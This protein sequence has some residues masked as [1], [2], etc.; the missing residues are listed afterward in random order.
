MQQHSACVQFTGVV[1]VIND[2][3]FFY[4]QRLHRSNKFQVIVRFYGMLLT[5]IACA[6]SLMSA[7][8]FHMVVIKHKLSDH[9]GCALYRAIQSL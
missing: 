2:H 5:F 1:V 3:L 9:S 4:I 8:L 6:V 7:E